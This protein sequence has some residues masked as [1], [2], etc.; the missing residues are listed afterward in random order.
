MD[1]NMIDGFDENTADDFFW[2]EVDPY[3]KVR[4]SEII[5]KDCNGES[6]TRL[7]G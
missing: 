1:I 6:L 5:K 7:Y 3:T 4:I 2:E